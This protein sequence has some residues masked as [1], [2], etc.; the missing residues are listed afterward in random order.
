[1]KMREGGKSWSHAN[2]GVGGGGGT[3]SCVLFNMGA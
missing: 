1:M 3:K 2:V